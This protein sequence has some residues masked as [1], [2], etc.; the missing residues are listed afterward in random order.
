[1]VTRLLLGSSPRVRGSLRLC[2]RL[3]LVVGIIPAGAGLTV[4]GFAKSAYE[5]DHPRGCGAHREQEK[6]IKALEGSS[7]RVRGSLHYLTLAEPDFGIIPAGAG[8]TLRPHFTV[9]FSGDHPRGCGAHRS[10]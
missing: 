6:H 10:P 9:I 7:P 4:P 2:V 3:L 8:L 1:M 5:R